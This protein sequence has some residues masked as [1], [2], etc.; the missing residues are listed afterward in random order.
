MA[1][2]VKFYRCPVCASVVE[3]IDGE[4]ASLTCHGRPM[5][6]LEARTGG[7]DEEFHL[8]VIRKRDGILYINVGAK[9]HPQSE[10]HHI[11]FIAL[12]T[13]KTV[14]RSDIS[15]MEAPATVFTEKDHGDVYVYCTRDGL[16]KASF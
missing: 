2:R 10:E 14:R 13:K 9:M 1:K 16:W 15:H 3:L 7:P 5:E 12:V 11:A 4:G 6:L 8:P